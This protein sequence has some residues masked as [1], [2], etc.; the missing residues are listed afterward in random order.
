MLGYVIRCVV[1]DEGGN[2]EIPTSLIAGNVSFKHARAFSFV[3]KSG[4]I[5]CA[6]AA[7][8]EQ[9]LVGA[10]SQPAIIDGS[11]F[12][13]LIRLFAIDSTDS[14]VAVHNWTIAST[15]ISASTSSHSVQVPLN[16]GNSALIF[17]TLDLLNENL[18]SSGQRQK[19]QVPTSSVKNKIYNKNSLIFRLNIKL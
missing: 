15:L 16:S 10:F 7:T 12:R 6:V 11:D 9:S 4:K 18:S 8:N 14:L 13:P 1:E 3:V 5:S 17:S 2:G 19:R